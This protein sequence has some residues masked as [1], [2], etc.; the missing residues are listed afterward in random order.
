MTVPL[1]ENGAGGMARRSRAGYCADCDGS[2]FAACLSFGRSSNSR[3]LSAAAPRKVKKTPFVPS[4]QAVGSNAARTPGRRAGFQQEREDRRHR[5]GTQVGQERE[6]QPAAGQD[7]PDILPHQARDQQQRRQ[8]HDR[9]GADR[10]QKQPAES[11][12]RNERHGSG[13]LFPGS[14]VVDGTSVCASP[15]DR[16]MRQF[17]DIARFRVRCHRP[18]SMCSSCCVFP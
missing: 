10:T 1:P 3:P 16:G 13:F 6:L 5:R 4:V 9:C 8:E 11:D 14:L 15:D 17:T 18:L 2:T 7:R 12:E